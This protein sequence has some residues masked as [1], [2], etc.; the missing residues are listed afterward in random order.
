MLSA[1]PHPTKP[2]TFGLLALLA[3]LAILTAATA[4][5]SR[6]IPAMLL[7]EFA[8]PVRSSP[9]AAA[10]DLLPPAIG[11]TVAPPGETW[12]GMLARIAAVD[13]MHRIDRDIYCHFLAVLRPC[14]I[15]H[16]CFAFQFPSTPMRIRMAT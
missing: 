14:R 8:S 6:K 4:G 3:G 13:A 7:R 10:I 2:R 11:L 9:L 1:S 12:A 5:C 15:G 16:R